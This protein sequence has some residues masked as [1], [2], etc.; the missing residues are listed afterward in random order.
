VAPGAATA[1][2]NRAVGT[3]LKAVATAPTTRGPFLYQALAPAGVRA[4]TVAHTN[5]VA[6][7]NVAGTAI[8]AIIVPAT[9]AGST[10]PA[11]DGL[12]AITS[13]N[14]SNDTA[15]VVTTAAHGLAANA[16]IN[17]TGANEAEYNGPAVVMVVDSARGFKYRLTGT[18]A[19]PATGAA[20]WR[21]GTNDFT[22]PYI[23]DLIDRK[24]ALTQP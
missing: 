3:T 4:D 18:P 20:G 8:S 21:S 5:A 10:A 17:V 24:P 2:V 7:T 23:L 13:I 9:A 19:T 16:F 6:G 11:G 14:R 12:H 22:R 15:T 1:Y